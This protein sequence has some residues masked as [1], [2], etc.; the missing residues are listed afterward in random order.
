MLTLI[1]CPFHPALPKWH[2]KDPCRSSKSTDERLHLN[3][4]I[5]LT[6]RRRSVLTIVSR[7]S[8]G[9]YHGKRAHT[10][11]IREHSATVVSIRCHKRCA[12]ADPHL[13]KK[14]KR[15]S[16]NL[17]PKST[18]ARKKSPPPLSASWCM[19]LQDTEYRIWI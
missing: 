5:P 12:Q 18:Q 2:V 14:K 16:L 6:R 8:V 4:H 1:R 9:T 17:P 11:L 3:T 15:K 19:I 10:Q 7:N 13:L